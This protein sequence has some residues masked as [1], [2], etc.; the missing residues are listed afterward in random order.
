MRLLRHDGHRSLK[1]LIPR[2]HTPSPSSTN[3]GRPP[4]LAP[5]SI[6]RR[7]G[8]NGAYRNLTC[9]GRFDERRSPEV[10]CELV[11]LLHILKEGHS[12]SAR[13][14][15]LVKFDHFLGDLVNSLA[16]SRHPVINVPLDVRKL[17]PVTLS[18]LHKKC[19]CSILGVA[20]NISGPLIHSPSGTI[21]RLGKASPEAYSIIDRRRVKTAWENFEVGSSIKICPHPTD[22]TFGTGRHINACKAGERSRGFFQVKRK[23]ILV[24]IQLLTRP[25]TI[26]DVLREQA[27][28][29]FLLERIER[30]KFSIRDLILRVRVASYLLFKVLRMTLGRDDSNRHTY[31]FERDSVPIRSSESAASL[32]PV[33]HA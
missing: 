29:Y 3:R 7:A 33:N 30:D 1:S 25:K 23:R 15:R 10:S 24:H 11:N 27:V 8:N 28:T 17:R 5:P 12:K 9:L 14:C 19:T 26:L 32:R 2:L 6:S 18:P 21:Q 31:I 22:L 20:H 4:S 13:I 16:I